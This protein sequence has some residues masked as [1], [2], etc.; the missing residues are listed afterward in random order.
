M[1]RKVSGQQA[2]RRSPTKMSGEDPGQKGPGNHPGPS[3][4][5]HDWRVMSR[6]RVRK[7]MVV[8]YRQWG[9]GDKG[10]CRETSKRQ[11]Q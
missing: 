10:R 5:H 6:G 9:D 8:A 7:G 3:G 1:T 2:V 11:P 4:S